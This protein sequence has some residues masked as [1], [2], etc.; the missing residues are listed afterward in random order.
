MPAALQGG[1]LS[2]AV[3]VTLL[4]ALPRV[5][6]GQRSPRPGGKD[7]HVVG[8]REEGFRRTVLVPRTSR[9]SPGTLSGSPVCFHYLLLF[10]DRIFGLKAR[11]VLR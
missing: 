5:A 11:V 1:A 3:D 2:L 7:P 6:G 8:G 10:T 9:V 4:S